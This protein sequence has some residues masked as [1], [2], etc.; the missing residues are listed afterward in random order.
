[1]IALLPPRQCQ[2]PVTLRPLLRW[3]ASCLWLAMSCSGANKTTLLDVPPDSVPDAEKE[4]EPRT[5]VESTAPKKGPVYALMTQVYG[6]DERSVYVLLTDTLDPADPS[7]SRAREF[8]GVANLA[9]VGGRLLVSDGNQPLITEYDIGDDLNWQRGASVNFAE[10]PLEDN[11]N[12][13]YQFIVDE[14]TAYLPYDGHKRV[15]WDPTEMSITA[16]VD[17][18]ELELKRGGLQLEAGGNR[19]G[20]RYNDSVLQAFFYHDEG[21]WDF[22]SESVVASYDTITH[23]EGKL[24]SIPCPGL[25]IATQDE[26]GYTY[27]GT[28]DYSPL[29]ALYGESPAPCVARI[30]PDGTL[31]E[32]WTTD[33]TDLTEG[34][35]SMNFRYIGDDRAIANVLHHE[36]FDV[37][38]TDELNFD[39]VDASWGT[40]DHWRLWLFDLKAGSARP[41]EGIDVALGSGAQFAILDGRTFVFIPFDDY[42]KTMIYE[43][44]SQGRASRHFEIPG[45]VYQW[46]RVR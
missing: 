37:D 12:F 34:R 19:A 8:P 33:L 1:M 11:A 36:V 23:K 9:P 17:A 20:V 27:F 18:S 13:Y 3:A 24:V 38:F 15:I 10:Y 28:Y 29:R 30:A 32:S 26:Q 31:D 44:N 16:M 6:V 46:V 22:G 39:V 43:L 35:Y 21:W 5:I 4:Q 7:L 40:G 41:V 14:H 42:S 2:F 25:A 45:N